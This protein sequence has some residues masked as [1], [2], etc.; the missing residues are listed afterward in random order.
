MRQG[1]CVPKR[2]TAHADA[3]VKSIEYL[4]NPDIA[5]P[6]PPEGRSN[7]IEKVDE[8]TVKFNLAAPNPKFD[9]TYLAFYEVLP[10]QYIEEVGWETFLEKPV[11]TGPFVFKEWVKGSHVSGTANPNYWREG[12]P[13]VEE[14]EFKFISDA[15]NR[16]AALQSGEV[17]VITAYRR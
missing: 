7:C 2:R 8:Y 3:V 13:L 15:S 10:P 11:G 1:V 9:Y 16:M 17:D 4:R 5:Y 12:Y 6:F 14:I